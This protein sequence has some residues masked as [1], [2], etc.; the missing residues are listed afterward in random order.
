MAVNNYYF[1]IPLEKW[2]AYLK[3]IIEGIYGV[4]EGYK[5]TREHNGVRRIELEV[6]SQI[7]LINSLPKTIIKD[8]QLKYYS[9]DN[10]ESV[11]L[12]INTAIKDYI[13]PGGTFH[14]EPKK[15]RVHDFE[16]GPIIFQLARDLQITKFASLINN[17]FIVY[18]EGNPVVAL[19]T[20]IDGWLN[21]T[22]YADTINST[23]DVD[24]GYYGLLICMNPNWLQWKE[25]KD[26][27]APIQPP[28][29]V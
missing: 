11:G 16:L 21:I 15:I 6:N 29:Y 17:Q 9:G 28:N 3:Y 7:P 26:I 5:I 10:L 22:I 24:D 12:A 23:F 8:E 13:R 27:T 18:I 1:N 14:L 2:D 4:K 25:V 19:I 20:T